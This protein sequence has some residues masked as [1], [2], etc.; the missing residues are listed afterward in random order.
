MKIALYAPSWPPGSAPNGIVTY[1]SHLAPALRRLGHQ[2]YVL[3][4]NNV[5]ATD[6][7]TIDL[8]KF[9][10]GRSFRDRLTWRF[11]PARGSFDAVTGAIA[12]AISELV[13]RNEIDVFEIEESF[14]WSLP[15]SQRKLLPVVVRLHGPWILTGRFNDAGDD[16]FINRGKAEREGQAIAGAQCVTANCDDT[17]SFVKKHYGLSLLGSRVIPTPI[18]AVAEEDRWSLDRCKKDSMLFIGRFDKLKGGDLVLQMFAELADSYPDLTLTFVGPDK[19]IKE[20]DGTVLKFE[21]FVTRNV[22]ERLRGRIDF[23]GLMKHADLMALRAKHFVTVIAAQ[24]DTMGYML[25]EPMSF[26]CPIVSTAVGGIPEVIKDR[27]NGLLVPSQDVAAM[28]DACRTLLDDPQLAVR[29]GHQAWEDC[30]TL[31]AP[32]NVAQQTVAAYQ[33]A[34]DAFRR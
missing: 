14:G 27:H 26:G 19:G 12:A 9:G 3:T 21:E 13:A 24:Y 22:P 18:D 30:R 16:N 10:T 11:A 23:R 7:F 5:G 33:A 17:L 20:P 2:V 15:L 8:K 1:T 29:L 25:L 28:A 4:F 31:Y 32:D 6:P 34:I